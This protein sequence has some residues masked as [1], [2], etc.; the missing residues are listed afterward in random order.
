MSLQVC[1]RWLSAANKI[2]DIAL[3]FRF[4]GYRPQS[5]VEENVYDTVVQS[6]YG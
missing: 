3:I 6:S 4:P 1:C 5:G 2:Y